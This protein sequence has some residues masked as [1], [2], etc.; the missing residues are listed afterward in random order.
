MVVETNFL[1]NLCLLLVPLLS[2][3][4]ALHCRYMYYRKIFLCVKCFNPHL[5]HKTIV[6]HYQVHT[7]TN[8]IDG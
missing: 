1:L 3:Y 6:L 2:L 7:Y 8:R 5:Y 4:Y